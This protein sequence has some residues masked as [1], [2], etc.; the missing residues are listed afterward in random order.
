MRGEPF[1]E[2][3]LADVR[4]RIDQTAVLPRARFNSPRSNVRLIPEWVIVPN[5]GEFLTRPGRVTD[6]ILFCSLE[7]F[8][9]R[10]VFRSVTAWMLHDRTALP[11][12]Q[13]DTDRHASG[14]HDDDCGFIAFPPPRWVLPR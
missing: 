9:L 6:G 4:S 1:P 7:S 8:D 12:A 3:P 2:T 11:S 14:C 13:Q 10:D 5:D